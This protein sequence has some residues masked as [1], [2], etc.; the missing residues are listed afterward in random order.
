MPAFVKC[1]VRYV[2]AINR[3]VGRAVLYLLFVI[4]GILLFSAVSRYF[5]D[6]PVI[7]GVEMAQFAMVAY[8]ILGGGFALLMNSHVRMD[9][10]YA[11]MT[12][13]RR[14]KMD[15][16]TFVFL[17][18]YLGLLLYGSVSSTLYSFEFNQHNNS[19]WAP[20][21]APVKC[22]ITLGILLTLLQAVSEFFKDIARSKGIVLGVDVPEL[23]LV[24]ANSL[25][26][27]S[28][29]RPEKRKSGSAAGSHGGPMTGSPVEPCPAYA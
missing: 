26:K 6:A 24:E 3:L 11:R 19:A 4:M 23:Q 18:I 15:S 17:I 8:F 16:F 2:D 1:Y 22:I 27:I 9:V 10:F 7:W 14:A 20:P 25:D 13:R 12:W 28:A 5:F 29:G 21:I